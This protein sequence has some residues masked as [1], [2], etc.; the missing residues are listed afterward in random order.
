MTCCYCK[1]NAKKSGKFGPQKTQRYRCL[2]CG[3][4]FSDSGPLDDMRIPFEK[5]IQ[6]V[7]FL[8]E[9]VGINASARLAGVNKRTVL[10]VLALAGERCEKLMDEKLRGLRIDDVQCDEI[11]GI[12]QK[13]QNH[14]RPTED[15]TQVGDFYTYVAFG[16]E[17]KLV[18]TSLVGKRNVTSTYAFMRDLSERIEGD[19]QISTDSFG[20]YRGAIRI[21]FGPDV[22]YGQIVKFYSRKSDGRYS[23][24]EVTAVLKTAISGTPIESKIC[25]SHVERNNLNMRTF[26]RRLT[27]LCLGFSKKVENLKY[28]V[29]LFFAFYNFCRVHGTLKTTPAV[30]AGVESK[31]WT[32]AD[33][34]KAA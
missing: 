33:L 6:I 31:V 1:A 15:P 4:T 27:R 29:S 23:P 26:M 19:V 28:A 18:I 7:N 20:A 12:V 30:A 9:G 24:P 22:D 34:L 2:N 32:I 21:A 10:S 16:R 3:K 11:W 17:S 25:T 13:K 14:I 8:V 5:A